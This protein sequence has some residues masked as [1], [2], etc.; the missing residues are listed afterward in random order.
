MKVLIADDHS[1]YRTGLSFLLRD[2]LGVSKVIEVA[3]LDE[4]LD[5]LAHEKEISLALFDLSM[6]G[7]SGPDSLEAV[8]AAY[9]EI[10]I[11]V[12]SATEDRGKVLRAVSVGLSGYVPRAF[13]TSKSPKRLKC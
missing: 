6:P 12:I 2:Q 9:P 13:P 3:T 4:A 7:M 10:A 1:L 5:L 11:A 8:K